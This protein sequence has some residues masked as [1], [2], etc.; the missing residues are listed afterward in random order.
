VAGGGLGWRRGAVEGGASFWRSGQQADTSD[1]RGGADNGKEEERAQ[2]NTGEGRGKQ[3]GASV[4]WAQG[5]QGGVRERTRGLSGSMHFGPKSE[6]RVGA[7]GCLRKTLSVW[8]A[9]L[10]RVFCLR[11]RV[12]MRGGRL[13]RPAGDA[14]SG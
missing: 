3:L 7:R 10:G 6:T 4:G 1:G 5:G 11:G 8:V 12:R 13:S 2:G 9:L 14:L